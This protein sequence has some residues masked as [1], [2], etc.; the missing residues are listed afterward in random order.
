MP[1]SCRSL[2]SCYLSDLSA[3]QNLMR[4]D[5]A[6][7]SLDVALAVLRGR[8]S[9]IGLGVGGWRADTKMRRSVKA[10]RSIHLSAVVG[11]V[12]MCA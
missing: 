6:R 1:S 2:G 9:W 8:T 3:G 10:P 11:T 5:C 7:A 12:G 4:R